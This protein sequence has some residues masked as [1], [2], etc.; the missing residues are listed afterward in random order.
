VLGVTVFRPFPFEA[1]GAALLDASRV[2]V[3]ERAFATGVGGIVTNEVRA[4]VPDVPCHT[5][6]AGLG[7]RPV[8]AASLRAM[9]LAAAV[10]DLGPLT[11]LD[12]NQDLVDRELGRAGATRRSGPT[13]EN[14]LADLRGAPR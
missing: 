9:L 2:V 4:A 10:G 14:L 11:F 6:V 8:T 12:L 1:V 7:G 5:V 13:A 3:L